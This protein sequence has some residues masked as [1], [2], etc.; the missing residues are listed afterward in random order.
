MKILDLEPG[1]E[2]IIEVQVQ[3]QKLEFKTHIIDQVKGAAVIEPIRMNGKF[4]NLDSKS[5]TINIL[6]YKE[7]NPPLIWKY[8]SLP[9]AVYKKENCYKCT[10][11]TEG[12]SINRRGAYRL[13]VGME[14]TAQ[15]GTAKKEIAVMVKDISENGFA[16]IGYRGKLNVSLNEPVRLVFNDEK[17]HLNLLGRLVR[18]IELE[19]ERYL[20]ACRLIIENPN[21]SKYI[22][23][24]QRAKL[25]VEIAERKKKNFEMIEK[26]NDE[27][28]QKKRFY[29]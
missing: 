5:V 23:E 28:D 3:K 9:A 16:F 27:L 18:I 20:Y 11:M 2:I 1:S 7:N 26:M 4:L 21:I 17:Y 13:Y 6:Y 22:A 8:V 19:N 14:G 10:V 15:V 25:A 24:K 12:T 29:H